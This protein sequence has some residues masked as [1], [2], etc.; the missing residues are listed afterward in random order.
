MERKKSDISRE[1]EQIS[2]LADQIAGA[3]VL[4][5]VLR[6]RNAKYRIYSDFILQI[7]AKMNPGEQRPTDTEA[8]SDMEKQQ[9]DLQYRQRCLKE[10]SNRFVLL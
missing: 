8:L 5:K 2:A 9:Q 4:L 7:H 3:Q 1:M 6:D 10:V